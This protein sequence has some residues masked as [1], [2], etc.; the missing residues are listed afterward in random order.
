MKIKNMKLMLL[1]LIGLMSATTAS[2]IITPGDTRKEGTITYTV[3]AVALDETGRSVNG[4]VYDLRTVTWQDGNK[5]ESTTKEA[6]VT[7]VNAQATDA[8]VATLTIPAEV[9]GDKGT[10]KVTEITAGWENAATMKDVRKKTTSLSIDIT[11]LRA[12]LPATAYSTF[13]ALTSLT[14]K[15]A[16]TSTTPLTASFDG[17]GCAFQATLT[18]LDL[19]QSRINTIAT[20]GLKG[21]TALTG[22]DFGTNIN[23]VGAN[24]FDG[25][26][27]IS[28]LTIPAT[29]VGIGSNAFDNMYLAKTATT[30][31]KG[32]ATLTINGADNT[33]NANGTIKTSVI[34]AAFAGN[35]LLSSVKVGST[36]ATDIASGAFANAPLTSID[37]S[38]ATALATITGAFDTGL[39]L[40]SVQLYGSALTTLAATD[41]DLSGSQRSL[42]AITLPKGLTT[43]SQS[44]SDF[45]VLEAIDLS[46]T[47]VK[48]IPANEFEFTGTLVNPATK[49]P[50]AAPK[51]AAVKLNA[52][53]TKINSSAFAGQSVLT[54]I[55][56]LNQNKLEFIGG[57]AFEG[58]A[59]TAIDLSAAT[60]SAFTTIYGYTFANMES[61]ATI[62]LPAQISSMSTAAFANDGAVTSINLEALTKLTTLNP[63]FHE[64]VVG[65]SAAPEVAIPITSLTLPANLTTINDGA[66][67]LLD[68]TEID[69]PSKVTSIG[70]YAMQG[71]IKLKNFTWN[72]APQRTIANN[73]FRGDDHLE[74]VKMVTYGGIWGTYTGLTIVDLWGVPA[75][76]TP[77]DLIFQGNKKDVLKFVVNAED[78]A[79]LIAQGWT[80]ANLQF[81]TLT[82]EGAST[83]TFSEKSKTG[84]YY[85]ATHY[86]FNQATWFPEEDF[87]V[88]AAVV[89]GSN[90][91]LSAASTEGGYYKVSTSDVC[92]VRSKKLEADYELKNATFNDI[93]T[94]PALNDLT[95]APWP[96]TPSRLSYQYI[97]GVKGGVV[98]FY[99]I[100]SG[101]IGT[102]KVYIN[103][104]TPADR[105]NIVF[106]GEA[107]AIQG[108][109]AEA[110]SNAPIYNLNGVRV[111]K[112][113]KGVYIQN[114]K[115]FVK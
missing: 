111:N 19:T 20:N 69:I 35:Y 75:N 25:D 14:I 22:F 104:A 89:E 68:I 95:V 86:N 108:F 66:L 33:Y 48:K 63:I 83:F 5:T 26:Y 39:A 51:L 93:S 34:P 88:F 72:D 77:V 7:G 92:V 17:S 85:Y 106:D 96:V 24:A 15:D 115:K 110:E 12:A 79:T 42:T 99:R 3:T 52:E 27:G 6:T 87:E 10:Y 78:Q 41:L 28:T 101:T 46:V 8:E 54:S 45:V 94:M 109:K 113:G 29:V 80:E 105:L 56:G 40:Q 84:E 18:T 100:T 4:I 38:G 9:N 62:T 90:V 67:Q 31:A 13:S 55:E 49:K 91:V 71:C 70:Q 23:I 50:Y 98:A 47:G 114:G 1:G 76:D 32:L 61:L 74:S 37:L 103:A 43:L 11:N 102:G 112:A 16:S 58:T 97:L 2:A 60:N 59:L 30:P 44:F 82:A 53:T 21:Y 73:A 81:C 36:T 64:G 57:Y 107:T 65:V